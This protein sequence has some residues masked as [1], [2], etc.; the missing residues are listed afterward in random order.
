[1][2]DSEAGFQFAEQV[3]ALQPDVPIMLQSGSGSSDHVL[4]AKAANVSY[5]RKESPFLLNNLRE[6]MTEG[7]GFGDFIFRRPDGSIVSVAKD[8]R[9]LETQLREAP[10][11]SVAFHGAR[12][13][14]SRWLKARTEFDLAH[15]LRPRKLSDYETVEGLRD[16]LVLSLIHI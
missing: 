4:R 16:V 5:V 9:Q 6:F 13:H 14:F 1:M 8:L 11:E 7:F 15:F 2:I 10:A 3:R 12:N